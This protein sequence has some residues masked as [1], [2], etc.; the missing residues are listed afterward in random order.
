MEKILRVTHQTKEGQKIGLFIKL[1]KGYISLNI[2]S[3]EIHNL[4]VKEEKEI[5]LNQIT[6]EIKNI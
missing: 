6:G 5:E 2:F 1:R 4:N 3:G